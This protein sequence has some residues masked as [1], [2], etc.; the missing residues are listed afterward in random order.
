MSECPNALIIGAG[1]AG[2]TSLHNYLAAHPKIFGS[3]PKE[4]MYFT[5]HYGKEKTGTGR[6]FRD[7]KAWKYILRV[8]LSIP[9]ETSFRKCLNAYIIYC[10]KRSLYMS[11][12]N[13]SAASCLIT[14]TGHGPNPIRITISRHLLLR[15]NIRNTLSSAAG[16]TTRYRHISII[17]R[18]SKSI[19]CLPR[20]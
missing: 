6:T 2:S 8:R 19:S 13:P 10:Q 18:A 15:R 1:K 4:I 7:R 11:F 17:F 14:I 16:T 12:G 3:D 9:F 20:T 5:T